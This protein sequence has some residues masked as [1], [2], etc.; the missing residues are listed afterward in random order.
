[1]IVAKIHV[2]NAIAHTVY[3]KVI[4]AGVIGAQ[5]E[6]EYAEDVWSGLHKTVVFRGPVTKD[7]VTDANIVTIPPEVVEKPLY[8]LSVGVYGLDTDGNLAIPT[9][10]ADLGIVRESANPS[11]DTTTDPSLPVWAQIKQIADEAKQQA[12]SV[13]NDADSGA[14]D[15]A[16]GPQGLQG[17]PGIPG[18]PGPQGIPGT[19]GRDGV[20]GKDGAPGADGKTPEYGVD[21]GTPEQIAGIAQQAAD[22]L[23][24]EVNQL[25]KDIAAEAKRAKEAEDNRIKKFYTGNLGAVSVP[26]SDDGAVRNLVIWGRSEQFTTTGAQL[27]DIPSNMVDYD[28]SGVKWTINPDGS[29]TAKGATEE[30]HSV[31]QKYYLSLPIGKYTLSV[32]QPSAV[33]TIIV[34]RRDK[35]EWIIV[36]GQAS[37][38]FTVDGT[39][40]LIEFYLQVNPQTTVDS[41]VYPMLNAG[42]TAIPWEPYTGGAPSPSPDYPQE[43][44]SVEPCTM[45]I[46]NADGTETQTA[47][48]PVTLQGIGDVRDELYVYA[49][50]TGKLVRRYPDILSP[51]MTVAE[52]ALETP[53]ETTL[54]AEQVKA[55]F[56]LRTYYGGTNVSFESENGVEPVVNFDYACAIENFVEYIKAAQGDNRKFIYDM[57]ERMTDAEYVA[58]MAY[59]N[60][61]YASALAELMEV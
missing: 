13:R 31:M 49:D 27:L 39:E 6:F 41:T 8:P 25:N 35:A 33:R 28:I 14:F 26:D 34:L 16:P 36:R 5:V 21:Y 46:A 4:P 29:I 30:S 56:D 2:N 40:S 42:D 45:T 18:Q 1:M 10:W 58:A 7:V 43:I 54:T 20:D 61:E 59:V 55:L 11:G 47:L 60:S 22:V 17:P 51:T 38:T 15:G 24:P 50:G 32:M 19:D 52:Q 23:R 37:Q 53:I 3:R 57:G 48:I 12:L 44:K 9:I